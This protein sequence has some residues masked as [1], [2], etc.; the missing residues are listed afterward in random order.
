M[1]VL[2]GYLKFFLFSLFW[3]SYCFSASLEGRSKAKT[4][5]ES[6]R[7]ESRFLSFFSLTHF[8]VTTVPLLL[9]TL[10]VYSFSMLD[11]G[12][13]VARHFVSVLFLC[14]FHDFLLF[15]GGWFDQGRYTRMAIPMLFIFSPLF[16]VIFYI[17]SP[18]YFLLLGS[19]FW[20][21][22]GQFIDEANHANF[23]PNNPYYVQLLYQERFMSPNWHGRP[24][25][26]M[27]RVMEW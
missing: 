9:T 6:S 26:C 27:Q 3:L 23:S 19:C 20:F 24:C 5:Y 7:R 8:F 15:G 12:K 25:V 14:V 2:Q 1:D 18:S 21:Q 10:F 17:Y 13:C 11:G 4:I 16:S 22:L